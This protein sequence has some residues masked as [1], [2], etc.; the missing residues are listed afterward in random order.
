VRLTVSGGVVW[1]VVDGVGCVDG[2]VSWVP[3]G[4]A[5]AA[6]VA[7]AVAIASAETLTVSRERVKLRIEGILSNRSAETV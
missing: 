3:V 6:G 4:W 1:L 2:C 7:K 5:A